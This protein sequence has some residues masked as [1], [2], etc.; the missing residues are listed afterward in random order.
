MVRFL[1]AFWVSLGSHLWFSADSLETHFRLTWLGAFF[2]LHIRR[3]VGLSFLHV[4]IR[5]EILV[6]FSL[7]GDFGFHLACFLECLGTL[8]IEPEL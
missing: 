2:V 8:K 4:F 3:L 5:S 1:G 7:F 6:L